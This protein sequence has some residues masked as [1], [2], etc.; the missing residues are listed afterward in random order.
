MKII[1]GL[2]NPGNKYALT[3]HNAGFI[4]LDF[5]ADY[6]KCD[7][8]AGKGEY[9]SARGKFKGE[10]FLLVKPVTY[11]NNSGIAVQ[12][13][14]ALFPDTDL[15]DVLIIF[16]DFQLT[17]GTVRI[18]ERGSDGGH[19]G[20]ASIIYHLNS[21]DVPRMRIGIGTGDVMKKDE[22]VD[23]VLS[24]FT[25][26]EIETLKSLLPVYKDCVLAFIKEPFKNVMNRFNKNF[27]A[28]ETE[29]KDEKDEKPKGEIQS[30]SAE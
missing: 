11:M 16:D 27:L 30:D 6:L 21:M 3:R 26:S 9:Y 22:F 1:V 4:V 10:D 14:L 23:F 15:K 28:K 5:L 12:E 7:F 2:G 24:N 25:E 18:R 19:N 8:N 29:D 13:V 20:I 17:L